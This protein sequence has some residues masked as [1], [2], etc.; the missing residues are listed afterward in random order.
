MLGIVIADE[1]TAGDLF[2]NGLGDIVAEIPAG[3]LGV[4]EE[5]EL[6][7]TVI[8]TVTE[9]PVIVYGDTRITLEEALSSW[10]SRLEKVYPTKSSR[11]KDPVKSD[12]Y[13]ADSVYVCRHKTAK[14]TVF[15]PVFP[16]TNCEYDSARAFERAGADVV[17]KV[18]R[19][20]SAQDIR[21][22]DRKSVV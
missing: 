18:F 22:S 19:N 8:G 21:E 5:K 16:G 14:P 6:D 11:D 7:Y 9:E 17:T 20:L 4:L 1:V 2:G 3:K 12:C 15:I 10:T 13:Q